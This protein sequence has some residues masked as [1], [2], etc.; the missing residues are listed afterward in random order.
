MEQLKQENDL[1]QEY[2]QQQI[3]LDQL[4]RETNQQQ[5]E[6]E[7]L[8]K[9]NDQQQIEIEQLK[10]ETDQQLIEIEQLKRDNDQQQIKINESLTILILSTSANNTIKLIKTLNSINENEIIN[11]IKIIESQIKNNSLKMV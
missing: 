11:K 3:E 4:M 6:I 9:D 8:N 5:I 10:R 7:Q 1:E 2:E